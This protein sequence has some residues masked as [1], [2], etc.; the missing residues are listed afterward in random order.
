ME[1]HIYNREVAKES[2]AKR[3]VDQWQIERSF[4]NRDLH[5][6]HWSYTEEDDDNALE[7]KAPPTVRYT[8][9]VYAG[10]FFFDIAR[11]GRL[12]QG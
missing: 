9:F 8:L 6:A 3:V 2:T 10:K 11:R 7:T 4:T 5:L 1:S 12:P